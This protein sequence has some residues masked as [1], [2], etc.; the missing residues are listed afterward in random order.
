MIGMPVSTGIQ[1][2]TAGDKKD[3][4]KK[5]GGERVYTDLSRTEGECPGKLKQFGTTGYQR[6]NST[7]HSK[8]RTCQHQND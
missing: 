4:E 7:G 6:I 1:R 5:P 2:G 3:G 8:D